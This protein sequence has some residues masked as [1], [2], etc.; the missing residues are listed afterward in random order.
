MAI[1]PLAD[2]EDSVI[3][4]GPLRTLSTLQCPPILL[5][6]NGPYSTWAPAG[7]H[8]VYWKLLHSN[9]RLGCGCHITI[10]YT[11][12]HNTEAYSCYE[13]ASSKTGL[14]TFHL[15]LE[16]T[17][18]TMI[19]DGTLTES[20]HP[21]IDEYWISWMFLECRS[22]SGEINQAMTTI[23]PRFANELRRPRW[24]PESVRTT[25]YVL[26]D[27]AKSALVI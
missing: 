2:W 20:C 12:V 10:P 13:I 21:Y 8:E 25:M 7:P 27:G 23:Q 26:V 4:A 14:K 3:L 11:H 5:E 6:C 19:Q 22:H 17:F 24:S 15:T 1:S 16:Y 18:R 9:S